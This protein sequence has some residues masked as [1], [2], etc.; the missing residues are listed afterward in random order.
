MAHQ[1]QRLLVVMIV[2]ALTAT[3]RGGN[4]FGQYEQSGRIKAKA[5]P[6]EI[7]RMGP[8]DEEGRPVHWEKL[9]DPPL[10]AVR[11]DPTARSKRGRVTAHSLSDSRCKINIGGM[12]APGKQISCRDQGCGQPL[13]Y[14]F[15]VNYLARDAYGHNFIRGRLYVHKIKSSLDGIWLDVYFRS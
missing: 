1:W 15:A 4:A 5:A 14:C 12:R 13:R 9:D 2:V 3:V 7:S 8:L 6:Q 11:A 10:G